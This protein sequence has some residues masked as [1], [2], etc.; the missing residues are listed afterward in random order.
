MRG[1]SRSSPPGSTAR[2]PF[3]TAAS[4]RGSFTRASYRERYEAAGGICGPPEAPDYSACRE[5]IGWARSGIPGEKKPWL[6]AVLGIVPGIGYLYSGEIATGIFAFLLIAADVIL[7]YF[8]FRTHNDVIGYFSGVIGGLFYAGSIAGGY[9][10]AQRYNVRR[11]EAAGSSLSARTEAWRATARIY[12]TGTVSAAMESHN[13][14]METALKIAFRQMGTDLAESAGGGGHRQGRRRHRDGRHGPLRVL[15]CG[16]GRAHSRGGSACA[17]ADMYV[18]LEPCNHYGKTPPCTEAIIRAGD[19][20]GLHSRAG[21]ESAGF[22]QGRR[23]AQESRH[24]RG[25]HGGDG[26]VR[27]GHYP[28]LQEVYHCGA[29][30]SFSA[31]AP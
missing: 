19:P 2:I 10:A 5:L 8:A 26:G 25:V 24:R 31:R 12:S 20:P 6:A 16:D 9:F 21:P 4:K 27:R 22:R 11:F 29:G 3:S 14:H 28:A 1:S 17:G 15:P 13:R 30:R 7:T 18:S 23:R